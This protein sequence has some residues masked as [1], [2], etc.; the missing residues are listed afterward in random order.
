MSL[1]FSLWVALAAPPATP[2]AGDKGATLT[3]ATYIPSMFFAGSEGK[4]A[5][6]SAVEKSLGSALN[7]T[8]TASFASDPSKMRADAVWIMD[9][10]QAAAADN[11]I[12]VQ[13]AH[14]K[15]GDSLPLSVYVSKKWN[16]AYSLLAR[17]SVVIPEAG[18]KERDLLRYWL[19]LDEPGA[20]DIVKRAK[21]VRDARAA[22][23]AAAAG[24]TDGALVF[25]A[26]YKSLEPRLGTLTELTW[27][28][29]APLPVLAVNRVA[30]GAAE[31]ERLAEALLKVELPPIAGLVEKWKAVGRGEPLR[32]LAQTLKTRQSPVSRKLILAPVP[33]MPIFL[34][35]LLP[36]P[37]E[38]TPL[39]PVLFM[40]PRRF[41][42]LP[43]PP[44]SVPTTAGAPVS[45]TWPAHMSNEAGVLAAQSNSNP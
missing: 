29:E 17:G 32:A 26:P 30:T 35:L 4:A 18:G 39:N 34:G 15:N 31:A 11:L 21:P 19:L 28:R 23:T 33:P 37:P 27:L 10:A 45:A 6:L 36:D 8:V 16:S 2:E 38:P 22:L 7:R 12:I 1:V 14:G 3:V 24:D 13:Q 43:D 44:T 5:F 42:P 25:Q 41:S 9:A 20:A 40:P